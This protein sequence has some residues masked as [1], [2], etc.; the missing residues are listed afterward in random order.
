MMRHGVG[1]DVKREIIYSS[2]VKNV[3]ELTGT[4]AFGQIITLLMV[5]IVARL[6]GPE[7]FGVAASILALVNIFS[8]ISTLRYHHAVVISKNSSEA[9]VIM[10]LGLMIAVGLMLIEL[11]ILLLANRYYS[12]QLNIWL[13]EQWALLFW[14]PVLAF[15]TGAIQLLNA[16]RTREKEYRI[17][18]KAAI[19]RSAMVP[20]SRIVFAHTMG[21]APCWLI[22][23]I[24]LGLI[25]EIIMLGV[26]KIYKIFRFVGHDFF[27]G[28]IWRLAKKYKDFPFYS[29]PEAMI[30]N[31]SNQLP[32]FM[33]GIM[34]S[35]EIVGLYFLAI[36][37]IKMP[38]YA[39]NKAVRQVFLQK[40]AELRNRE[41]T[42]YSPFIKSTLG[43]FL[44]GVIPFILLMFLA[45]PLFELLMGEEWRESGRYA[46]I[47]APWIFAGLVSV[48]AQ[49]TFV[50]FRKQARWLI[51]KV[52]LFLAR[53][54]SLLLGYMCGMDSFT[55]VAIFSGVNTVYNVVIIFIA[56]NIVKQNSVVPRPVIG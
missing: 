41:A 45:E 52:G 8:V 26:G 56:F 40:T 7:N 2:F 53:A 34:Y 48:P 33:L 15:F 25:V 30:N 54:G 18:G 35:P 14:A 28:P 13:S 42:V 21:A 16:W 55:V 32:I 43:L 49:T 19:A 47:L 22:I 44:L 6:Y 36:R 37:L 1:L 51:Y 12:E 50:V 20:G 38:V 17:V 4:T 31:F 27:R 29:A 11:A 5:P 24:G 10:R 39:L 23:S 9:E 46:V 3:A